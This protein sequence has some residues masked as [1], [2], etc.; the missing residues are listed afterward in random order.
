MIELYQYKPYWG[1]LNASPFCMKLEVYLQLANIPYQVHHIANPTKSPSGKLPFIKDGDKTI[2]DTAVIIE[3]LKK[4]Y[5]DELDQQLTAMQQAE[6]IA[7]QRMLEEHLYHILVYSRWIDPAGW[8]IVS[9]DFF[10][11]VPKPVKLLLMPL[12]RRKVK[13]SLWA[14]GVGRLSPANL[15]VEGKKDINALADFLCRQPY[16]LGDDVTGF[17]ATVYAFCANLVYTP[18]N[19]PLHECARQRPELVAYCERMKKRIYTNAITA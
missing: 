1:V 7:I 17:D 13:K 6:G 11:R 5:G 15:Y 16:L 10:N 9:K 3:Y 8:A 14:Q 19:S 12:I 2:T 4:T 18:I